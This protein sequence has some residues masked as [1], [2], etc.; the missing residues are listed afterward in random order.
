M[1]QERAA[2]TDAVWA[3]AAIATAPEHA[4]ALNTVAAQRTQHADTLRAEIDR[5]VGV[6]GDG[7]KPASPTPPVPAPAA[8]VPPPNPAAVRGRLVDS[9]KSAAELAAT[10]SGFRAGLLGSIS[11]C[12]ATHAKVLLA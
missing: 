4:A 9:Q 10:L 2:R 3:K 6:Y 7:T 1:E 8:P 5:A 11:A 12:C